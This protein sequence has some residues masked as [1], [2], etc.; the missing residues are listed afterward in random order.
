MNNLYF[1][2]ML[3]S[4]PSSLS[5]DWSNIVVYM[6]DVVPESTV[7][8]LEG[9]SVTA[10]CGSLSP[11][12]W[13]FSSR[14]LPLPGEYIIEGNSI[15]LTNLT[16]VHYGFY[17]CHG[18]YLSDTFETKQFKNYILINVREQVYYGEVLPN[19]VEVQEGSTVTL[20]CGSIKPVQWK[21]MKVPNDHMIKEDYKLTLTKLKKEHS[22]PYVCRGVKHLN[23]VFHSKTLIIVDPNTQ[24]LSDLPPDFY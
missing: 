8:I 23:R 4:I 10:H 22:G 11:V 13:T 20:T 12:T 15:T 2:L 6:T 3:V 5:K 24:F 19:H 17:F 14:N 21:T 7:N 18:T 16:E 9:D 1:I